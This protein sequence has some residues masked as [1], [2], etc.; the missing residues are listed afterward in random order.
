[1]SENTQSNDT[2]SQAATGRKTASTLPAIAVEGIKP[3][4]IDEK[5]VHRYDLLGIPLTITPTNDGWIAEYPPFKGVNASGTPIKTWG[6]RS[7][8][9]DFKRTRDH[10]VIAFGRSVAGFAEDQAE[11][12]KTKTSVAQEAA[13][14]E[15]YRSERDVFAAQ[16]L[17]MK[18]QN[19]K[20]DE[21]AIT[22]DIAVLVLA[23]SDF[24]DMLPDRI[25]KIVRDRAES[26]P[27]A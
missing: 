7:G 6:Y 1:M 20:L 15:A 17:V 16:V 23:D 11:A 13:K 22:K 18:V 3:V 24:M 5:G 19:R 4:R 21:D 2:Q 26:E 9:A 27:A 12:D 8:G 14:A 25:A 10:A